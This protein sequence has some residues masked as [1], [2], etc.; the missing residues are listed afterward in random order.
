MT[1]KGVFKKMPPNFVV[2]KYLLNHK[3]LCKIVVETEAKGPK[4][5]KRTRIVALQVKSSTSN[6][7]I[8]Y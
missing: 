1:I 3:T 4:L 8:P 5:N 2:Q 6:S 7:N